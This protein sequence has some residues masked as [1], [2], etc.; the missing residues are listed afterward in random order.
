MPLNNSFLNI[1]SWN[2]QSISNPSKQT[3]LCL[4]LRQYDIHIVCLQ[5]TFL[6]NTSKIHFNGYTLHRNDRDSH[7]GGVAIL[8]RNNIQ[9]K[10]ISIANTSSIENISVEVTVAHRKLV[11]TSAY[12]SKQSPDFNEDL[13]LLSPQLTETLVIGD[14]NAKHTDWNCTKIN[15]SG[16]KLHDFI[17]TTDYVIIAS[18]THTHYP[19]SGATPSTIDLALTN[20]T[21]PIDTFVALEDWLLSDHCPILCKLITA[22]PQL[23][24]TKFNY[25]KANWPAYKRSMD[26]LAPPNNPLSAAGIEQ[27]IEDFTAHIITARNSSVPSSLQ[28]DKICQIAQDTTNA[29]KFKNNLNRR[30]QRCTDLHTKKQLKTAVNIASKLVK[31][32]VSRDRNNNWQAFLSQADNNPRKMWRAS[33]AMRGK[34]AAIPSTIWQDNTKIVSD[35]SKAEAIASIFEKAHTTTLHQT[36][37]HD[38]KVNNFINKFDNRGPF[39]EA[40]DFTAEDIVNACST[41]RP[42][43]APGDDGIM[44]VLLKNLP[45]S[46]INYL[47]TVFNAC[48]KLNYWPKIFKEAKV[49]PIPKPGKDNT[50]AANYRPISLLNT[51]GKLFEKLIHWR[52]TQHADANNI[53]NDEQF[54]FRKQHSTSHQILRVTNHIK[55]N[56][57]LRK[58][59]GM[60]LFDIEKAFDSVWHDGLIFK[61]HKMGFPPYLCAM[62]KS[63][64]ASRT[65]KVHINA[66][67][68]SA[69]AIPAGLPQGSILSPTLYSIFVADLKFNQHT[70]S[71]CYADDTAIYSSAN[72]TTTIQKNLQKS[73]SKVENFFEKWKIKANAQKT[74]AIIFPFNNQ[75]KRRPTERLKLCDSPIDYSDSINYLGVTLD[76]KLNLKL[77]IDNTRKKAIKS[78]SA[79]YPLIS[80]RST[81]NIK[82]KLLL[83]K[84]VIRPIMSYASPIWRRAAP[85][86]RKKLQIVQNKCLKIIHNLPWRTST[87]E[88]H[89]TANIPLLAEFIHKLQHNFNIKCNN[90]EFAL[91]RELAD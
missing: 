8:V 84:A 20:S 91:I 39:T 2:A 65:F 80:R 49:V 37:P 63:F 53:I 11:I 85:T 51:T 10:V 43:K 58:S 33:R 31:E 27:A 18:D 66:D 71:A 77:H 78:M 22:V 23:K 30:W 7:G 50:K 81:L 1:I 24:T 19:H 13:L 9:H 56:W 79:L 48:L 64:T 52:I 57:G 61:L 17:D 67:R 90:S 88:L 21:L 12:S 73:L 5:E 70:Q 46:S 59:T 68:S 15:N 3:E 75:F 29:I 86:N 41:L 28:T 72:R 25:L 42:F 4:L 69:K 32:L 60:I 89:M 82:N 54:G 40:P 55:R 74:Q 38:A 14:L 34:R 76:K 45:P 26:L 35:A 62:I 87:T 16:K 83:Y 47:R 44:N 36:H 6:T